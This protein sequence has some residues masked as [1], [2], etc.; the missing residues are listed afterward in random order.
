MRERAQQSWPALP[1]TAVGAAA[2][3]CSRSASAKTTLADLPPSSSVTRLIG[4]GRARRDPPPHLRRAGEGDLGHV[5]C[6]T[7]RCPH[8]R[9]RP[10]TTFST[11]SG[12]PASTAIRSSSTAVSG[13]SSAG[14]ST[15]VLP[16]ASAGPTFQEAIA[17]GKFQGVISADHAERLAEG[18]VHAA[19]HGDGVAQQ[20]LRGAGVVVGTCRPPSPSRRARPRSACRRCG[21]RAGPA[22][23]LGRAPPSAT[24]RMQ[25]GALAGRHAPPGR[26]GLAR[27]LDRGVGLLHS[28]PRHLGHHLA[29]WRARRP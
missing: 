23:R 12:T 5:G 7:I 20:P 26:E 28:C 10:T 27:P 13:V 15:T 21:P 4:L 29:R 22:P 14:F 6:S 18:Q 3:A 9:P 8:T 17:I 19:G 1:N 25:R 16:A 11:P 24:A 2:A